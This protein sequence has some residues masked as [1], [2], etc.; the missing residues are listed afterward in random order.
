M[1]GGVRDDLRDY[2]IM[3]AD[4]EAV[5][6]HRMAEWTGQGPIIEED[7]AFSSMAQDELGH[8]VGLYALAEA[9]GAPDAD[10]LVYTR[11][12]GAFRN[13]VLVELPR[14]DYAFSL[15]RQFLYDAAEAER[16]AALAASPYAPLAELAAKILQ[17]ERY[18]WMHDTSIVRRLAGG[19]DDSRARMQAALD[20]A[21]PAALGLFETTPVHERLHAAGLVPDEQALRARWLD[22]VCATLSSYG[23]SVPCR[24][25]DGVCVPVVEPVSGG[26]VGAHTDHLRQIVDAM[27][28]L[29]RRD[30]GATW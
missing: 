20:A 7:I 23:L 13:A 17:E 4:D 12:A 9:L 8:A 15:M 21:Y 16:A 14:G 28:L 29:H 11:E 27:Q 5:L 24:R 30:P 10:T 19:T 2:C 18:H 1:T 25:D 6:G 26:R 22:T 3:L